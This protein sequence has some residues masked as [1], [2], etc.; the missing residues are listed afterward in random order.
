MGVGPQAVGGSPSGSGA[1]GCLGGSGDEA[2]SEPHWRMGSWALL[3]RQRFLFRLSS[4]D[5]T[6]SLPGITEL[7]S[8]GFYRA[9]F[10]PLI[11]VTGTSSNFL[12]SSLNCG[13]LQCALGGP[14]HISSGPF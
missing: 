14:A 7:D 1:V 8:R 11:W 10:K 12:V 9:C 5:L 2:S 13:D 6:L 4:Y 3:Q